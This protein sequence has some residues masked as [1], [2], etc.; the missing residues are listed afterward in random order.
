MF[1]KKAK[2]TKPTGVEDVSSH[3][4]AQLSDLVVQNETLKKQVDSLLSE[5]DHADR[6]YEQLLVEMNAREKVSDEVSRI[7]LME[8]NEII[9]TAYANADIIV[10]ESLSSERQ[11]LIEIARISNES[12][13]LKSSLGIKL[14]ALEHILEG[15]S[16]P[17]APSL[18]LLND[19][20][21]TSQID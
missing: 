8:S 7:A 18:I 19:E 21:D 4:E 2:Q 16:L 10:R 9:K 14:K 15:L 1:A 17:E 12:R 13:E 5:L 11:V 6:K 3:I 20:H